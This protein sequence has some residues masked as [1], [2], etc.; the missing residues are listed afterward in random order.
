[1]KR[2][3]YALGF[4][5]CFSLLASHYNAFAED[6][7]VTFTVTSDEA[8]I[9]EKRSGSLEQVGTLAKNQIFASEREY[10]SWYQFKLAG[11]EVYIH[12]NDTKPYGTSKVIS[13]NKVSD[14]EMTI[15]TDTIVY[16]NSGKQLVQFATLKSGSS[17]H[18]LREYTSWVSIQ[19]SNRIGFVKKSDVKITVSSTKQETEPK[20]SSFSAKDKYFKASED[21]LVYKKTSSGLKK[22]GVLKQGQTYPR[23]KDFSSWHEIQ[24]NEGVA[25]VSKANTVPGEEN[26]FKNEANKQNGIGKTIKTTGTTNVYDNSSGKLVSF[27]EIDEAVTLTVVKEYSS[28]YEVIFANRK[29]F[30]K[31]DKVKMIYTSDTNYFKAN[32]DTGIYVKGK[33]KLQHIG[34]I[35]KGQIYPVDRHYSSWIA[36][37]LNGKTAYIQKGKTSPVQKASLKSEAKTKQPDVGTVKMKTTTVVYDNTSGNLVPFATLNKSTTINATDV[38]SGWFKV[39][40]AGRIGYIKRSNATF[41]SGFDQYLQSKG[42]NSKQVIVVE[43]NSTK[44]KVAKLSVYEKTGD[45]WSRTLSSNAV[46]GKNGSTSKKRE[47]DGKTPIGLFPLRTAFGTSSK[48]T[49]VTYPYKKTTS[50]D[51][52]V[53]DTSSADYNKW[54][55]YKGN[56]ASKW[57]S[58]EK[59]A[60]PLYKYAVAIGYNDDPIVK[61]K[62][63]AIFLHVWRSSTSPTLGCVAIP[64]SNLVKVL[65]ELNSDKNPHILIGTKDVLPKIFTE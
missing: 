9:Y 51:Y 56:P 29:G 64:E 40:V 5:L 45:T 47:G 54:V 12:K 46:L 58:Y 19:F 17:Y 10:T 24:F 13:T 42:V 31:K 25:Y 60:I 32:V 49:N 18:V 61:G 55:T 38:Y 41:E 6:N 62:G 1:M 22:I 35:K 48:P 23:L 39:V 57:M 16:D 7:L 36:V 59:L 2:I 4:I 43:S 8:S 53:D 21:L 3:L 15:T 20:K 33:T 27:A 37:S 30:I 26:S 52:W 11:K 14:K 28:W 44:S 50:N 65:K 63:S 34:T